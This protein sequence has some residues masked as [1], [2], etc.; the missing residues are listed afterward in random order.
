M[1]RAASLIRAAQNPKEFGLATAAHLAA[2]DAT[3]HLAVNADFAGHGLGPHGVEDAHVAA[4]VPV[5]VHDIP[6]D[7][8]SVAAP[9]VD[10]IALAH[11]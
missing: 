2:P 11:H 6:L 5:A 9:V 4:S 3:L 7:H 8:H 1:R 10:H